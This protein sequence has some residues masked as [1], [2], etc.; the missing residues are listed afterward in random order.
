SVYPAFV[1]ESAI[2]LN[3]W[4]NVAQTNRCRDA[5]PQGSIALAQWLRRALPT[6]HPLDSCWWFTDGTLKELAQWVSNLSLPGNLVALLG[7]PTLFHY[8]QGERWDRKLFLV[9]RCA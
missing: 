9:D 6:C 3:L 5:S 1:R 8:L 2:R 7:T 4:K